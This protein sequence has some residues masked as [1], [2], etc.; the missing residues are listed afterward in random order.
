MKSKTADLLLRH[1]LNV[2]GGYCGSKRCLEA[3]GQR[4]TRLPADGLVPIRNQGGVFFLSS[5]R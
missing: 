5:Q 4:P 3:G 1:R 2:A